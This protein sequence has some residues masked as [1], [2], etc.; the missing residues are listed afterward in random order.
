MDWGY[1]MA[2]KRKY[3]KEYKKFQ[4][5]EEQ[6]K[7]RAKRNKNRDEAEK[8]GR[9]KKGDGKDVHHEGKKT[10]VMSAS[11]NRGKKEKSRVKGSKRK[12]SK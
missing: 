10:T 7:K 11:E 1:L 4:S 12:K 9:V 8:S 3:K 6:K 5:S 2:A